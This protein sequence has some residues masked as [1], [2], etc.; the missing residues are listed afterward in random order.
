MRGTHSGH[1]AEVQCPGIIPAHAGNT[2]GADVKRAPVWDHPRACGEHVTGQF[3]FPDELGSSPRMR[4]TLSAILSGNWT[5][6]IIPAHAGNTGDVIRAYVENG[7]HPRACGEHQAKADTNDKAAGSS[8]RM[9]GTPGGVV[10]RGLRVGIIPAHAGNTK[11]SRICRRC[12]RD[13]PRACG[14]HLAHV[15]CVLSDL[16]SSPRMRGTLVKPCGSTRRT[17]IIPAHAGNT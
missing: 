5:S 15:V 1:C 16:G 12:R 10:G 6:G 11:L 2:A 9:R 17:G 7:D 14:E 8:P 3:V 13:H 4:G